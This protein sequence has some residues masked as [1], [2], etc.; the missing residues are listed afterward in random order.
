[1]WSRIAFTIRLQYV[2]RA[3]YW[4]LNEN[5][6]HFSIFS[7]KQ[8]K[9]GG[10]GESKIS[11]YSLSVD[12]PPPIVITFCSVPE[13]SKTKTKPKSDPTDLN[14]FLMQCYVYFVSKFETKRQTHREND[15]ISHFDFN[16]NFLI[17]SISSVNVCAWIQT[18]RME[19]DTVL[20]NCCHLCEIESNLL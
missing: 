2:H 8:K 3:T 9:S 4:V 7:R 11:R 15:K 1:M 18:N 10:K 5:C 17:I 19:L 6:F 12:F 20:A 16:F 14:D 13:Q